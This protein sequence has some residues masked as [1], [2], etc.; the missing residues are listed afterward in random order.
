MSIYTDWFPPEI[1]PVYVGWYQCECCYQRFWWEDA[2]WWVEPE[3]LQS[4]FQEFSW[5]GL[6]EKPNE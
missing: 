3:L 2:K 1:K 5:R 6:K 4:R